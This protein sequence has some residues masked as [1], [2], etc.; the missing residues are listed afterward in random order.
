VSGRGA[1]R[2]GGR[3]FGDA[4]RGRVDSFRY[5]LRGVRWLLVTQPNARI[6]AAVTLGVCGLAVLL[7]VS[8]VEWAALALAIG[9]VWSAEGLNS[10]LEAL[11]D[12]AS[13][14][15]HPLV[16]RAKDM[17]AAAV[18]IAACGAAAV[19]VAILLPRLIERFA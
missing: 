14:E 16:A 18:L 12:V 17:A 7:D 3:S 6:H 1:P 19:G 9:A 5:A 10:A 11:C 8:R 13:P 15:F 2:A 4:L